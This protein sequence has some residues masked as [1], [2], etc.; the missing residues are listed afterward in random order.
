MRYSRHQAFFSRIEAMTAG[1]LSRL[2]VESW[3]RDQCAA[4]VH[5]TAPGANG[6]VTFPGI[7]LGDRPDFRSATPDPPLIAG[8]VHQLGN[9]E[10]RS[11][12]ETAGRVCKLSALNFREFFSPMP[13]ER[14]G[15]S[16]QALR[17]PERRNREIVISYR[18]HF[19]CYLY[20]GDP[21]LDQAWCRGNLSCH[22]DMHSQ[23]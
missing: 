7:L 13:H 3:L 19:I 22:N 16:G 18:L 12:Q 8:Q 5:L 15:C 6:P 17:K 20:H 4:V 9:K 11:F 1:T 2:M 14:L 21:D 10:R 23:L